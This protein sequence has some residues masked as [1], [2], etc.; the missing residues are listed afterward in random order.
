M[1]GPSVQ[2][3]SKSLRIVSRNNVRQMIFFTFSC[4]DIPTFAEPRNT[5]NFILL[6]YHHVYVNTVHCCLAN[7]LARG[8]EM[9]SSSTLDGTIAETLETCKESPQF[10]QKSELN[11][12]HRQFWIISHSA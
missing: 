7:K 4:L 2:C 12:T 1:L 5:Q 9:K 6:F 8:F 3:S 11:G 10:A